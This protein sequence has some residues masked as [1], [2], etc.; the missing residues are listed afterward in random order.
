MRFRTTVCYTRNVLY[1]ESDEVK[2]N[3][4]VVVLLQTTHYTI[5]P[6]CRRHWDI[7]NQKAVKPLPP[8][9]PPS[10]LPNLVAT[11]RLLSLSLLLDIRL[12]TTLCRL[13]SI[14]HSLVVS[15]ARLITREA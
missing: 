3:S 8:F 15:L 12:S 6:P 2:L 10:F 14:V 5:H 13:A 1:R 9:S 7:I 4:V 11:R